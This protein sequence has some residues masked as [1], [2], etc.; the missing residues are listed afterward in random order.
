MRPLPVLM[1]LLITAPLSGCIDAG[2]NVATIGL[3][4]E[5]QLP[6]GSPAPVPVHDCDAL[7]RI[8]S[9]RALEETDTF[10]DQSLEGIQPRWGW[11]GAR[12]GGD[13]LVPTTSFD[14]ANR[15]AT[16]V[17]AREAEVTGTNNQEAGVDEADVLKTDGEWT[18]VLRHGTLYI[19]R[20]DHVGDITEHANITFNAT[21][22]SG[23]ILL[24]PRDA[25][26]P[27]DDRLIVITHT[28]SDEDEEVY[29]HVRVFELLDRSDPSLAKEILI[30]GEHMGARLVD[31][32][33]YI[34]VHTWRNDLP[35]VT[36]AHPSHEDLEARG[37]DWQD[38]HGLEETEQREIRERLAD[39]ARL[40]NRRIL[41]DATLDDH[42][43][44]VLEGR[45]SNDT[46]PRPIGGDGCRRFLATEDA[47]GRSVST[48][49]ALDLTGGEIVDA[50]TQTLGSRPI[51]YGALDALVL[52]APSRDPWWFWDNKD[53][54]EAT[55]LQ[56]F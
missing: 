17:S 31:G 4:S 25:A 49:L 46:T 30:E 32:H 15:Q 44:R 3:F 56:W 43:P 23:Q 9:E 5:W 27:S 16:E 40:Q 35:L 54:E 29:A 13:I 52:A 20:S 24:A 34:V 50:T 48:I 2:P 45:G 33:A 22:H 19:L 21:Y 41:E 18:Y 51:V 39:E 28:Y 26:D 6:A 11:S 42:L 8:L 37:M 7:E 38:Y 10:L 47:T 14:T 36:H 53:I 1:A 55:D 12:I